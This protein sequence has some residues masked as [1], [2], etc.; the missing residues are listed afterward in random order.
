[1]GKTQYL[2][3]NYDDQKSVGDCVKYRILPNRQ[4]DRGRGDDNT[5]AHRYRNLSQEVR[6]IQD[7]GRKIFPLDGDRTGEAR[8]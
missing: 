3:N 1:M 7:K 2:Q 5:V 4:I 8:G 6:S